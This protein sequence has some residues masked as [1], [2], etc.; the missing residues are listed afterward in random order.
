MQN[1]QLFKKVISNRVLSHLVFWM[2]FTCF[3]GIMYGLHEKNKLHEE[4]L[5]QL[6]IL[7]AYLLLVYP[8]LYVIIP[9]FLLKQKILISVAFVAILMVL[10]VLA[11]RS[12]AWFIIYP[13]FYQD[14]LTC[15]GCSFWMV[16]KFLYYSIMLSAVL[17]LT[18]FIKMIKL[19]YQNQKNT[20]SLE[21]EKLEA[22]LKFLKGQ[23][24]PHFLFNTLNNLYA[25]TLKNDERAPEVVLKISE[26]M[27]YMLYETNSEWVSLEKELNYLKNYIS[28]ERIR[29][30]KRVEVNFNTSGEIHNQKIAPML[31]LP[32]VENSFKHGVSG[33]VDDAWVEIDLS[34]K[35][36]RLVL[37]VENSRPT[38][39]VNHSDRDYAKGI[40]LKNVKRRLELLYENEYELKVFDEAETYLV[41][42]KLN[43][44]ENANIKDQ[45]TTEIYETALSYR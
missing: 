10:S 18:T 7:P 43:L 36:N 23:I 6:I 15:E 31:L 30:G 38:L 19:W 21:Q 41:V 9:K 39:E 22:E 40:G 2:V 45:K 13:Y 44:E 16:Y 1:N 29:Y 4:L 17:F 37:K 34:V 26:L 8:S 5:S 33:Q 28:L 32:F 27:N 42:L 35:A 12:I 24:H 11:I 3:F 25:L 20:Q 14:G